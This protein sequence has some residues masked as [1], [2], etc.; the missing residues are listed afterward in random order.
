MKYF[1]IAYRLYLKIN[2]TMFKYIF[3]SYV[4]RDYVRIKLYQ[5]LRSTPISAKFKYYIYTY[6]NGLT[7]LNIPVFRI[8]EVKRQMILSMNM[9]LYSKI[10]TNFGFFFHIQPPDYLSFLIEKKSQSL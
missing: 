9:I 6:V 7:S 1:G 2:V 4:Q 10:E 8:V 5:K 3:I